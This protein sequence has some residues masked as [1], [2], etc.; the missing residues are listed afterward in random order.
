MKQ[1]TTLVII[2]GIGMILLLLPKEAKAAELPKPFPELPEPFPNML[3]W[4][5]EWEQ[6]WKEFEK[7]FERTF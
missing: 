2:V 4:S 3:P 5:E 6:Y 7:Y 1:W